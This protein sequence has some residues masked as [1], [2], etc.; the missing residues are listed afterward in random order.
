MSIEGMITPIERTIAAIQPLETRAPGPEP[1]ADGPNFANM[2]KEQL[3]EMVD[4]H[5]TAEQAQQNFLTGEITDIG[6]VV[7]A[8]QQADIALNFAIELRNKV[9]EAYMEISRMQI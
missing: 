9:I 1:G 5:N 7:L 2:L 6:E 8:I 4:L 3:N